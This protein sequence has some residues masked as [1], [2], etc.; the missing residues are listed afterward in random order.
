MPG[1]TSSSPIVAS[2]ASVAYSISSKSEHPNEAAAFLDYL[3]SADAATVQFDSGFM[4]VDTSASVEAEGVRADV[5][6]GFGEVVSADG[7]VPFPDFAAPAMIDT[8]ITGLQGLIS[9]KSTTD[10]FL[11]AMQ[12]TWDEY[13]G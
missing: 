11:A 9:K 2:G 13:H 5:A 3:A 6:S 12:Q 1:A 8:I 4:P 10:D 7:I